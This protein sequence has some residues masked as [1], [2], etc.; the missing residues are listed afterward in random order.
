MTIA[1]DVAFVHLAFL[2]GFAVVV[3]A[4]EAPFG[5]AAAGL[6]SSLGA[7]PGFAYPSVLVESADQEEAKLSFGVADAGILAGYAAVAL[8]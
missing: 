1:D 8:A 5:I 7:F 3:L 6:E 4:D 2:G